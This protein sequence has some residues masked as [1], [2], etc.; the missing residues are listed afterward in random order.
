MLCTSFR[1]NTCCPAVPVPLFPITPDAKVMG[2]YYF[3]SYVHS[4]VFL[5]VEKYCSVSMSL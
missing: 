3:L 2:S 5:K 1:Q 4:V